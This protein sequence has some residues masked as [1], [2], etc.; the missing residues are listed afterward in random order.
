MNKKLVTNFSLSNHKH[1]MLFLSKCFKE[2]SLEIPND[3][4][5]N[6]CI[7]YFSPQY[8]IVFVSSCILCVYDVYTTFF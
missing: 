7:K 6:K 5:I 3:H 4:K 2:N 8:V 1:N